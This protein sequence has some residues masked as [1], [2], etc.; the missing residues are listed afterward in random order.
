MK[1][2]WRQLNNADQAGELSKTS[3]HILMDCTRLWEA[4]SKAVLALHAGEHSTLVA[5]VH[6]AIECYFEEQMT[7][8]LERLRDRD[9][10]F[11]NRDAAERNSATQS[12]ANAGE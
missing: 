11:N 1:H 4:T 6:K 3:I 5:C 7:S 12:P 2:Y 8:I 10:Q 9:R